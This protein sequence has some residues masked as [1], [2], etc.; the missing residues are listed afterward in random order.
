MPTPA[1]SENANAGS[2]HSTMV[3]SMFTLAPPLLVGVAGSP[4]SKSVSLSLVSET[5]VRLWPSGRSGVGLPLAVFVT[6]V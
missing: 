5:R 6:P 4:Q 3:A 2:G 1:T